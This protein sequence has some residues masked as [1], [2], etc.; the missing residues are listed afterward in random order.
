M[1]EPQAA[2][3]YPSHWAWRLYAPVAMVLGLGTLAVLCLAWTPFALVAQWVFPANRTLRVGRM[4][5]HRVFNIYTRFLTLFC[6]CRFDVKDVEALAAYPG[7]MV[8]VANHPSLLDA[9]LITSRLPNAV[10]IMKGSLVRNVLLGAG[11]RMAGYIVNDSALTVVRRGV[12]A[13]KASPTKLVI[14]PE[15]SRTRTPPV[16]TCQSTAGVIAA[17]AGV[18]VAVLTIS[19]SSPY[20]G[21]QFPLLRPPQLPLRV[22]IKQI[23]QRTIDKASAQRFGDDIAGIFAQAL[24]Q[25]NSNEGTD[26]AST[27]VDEHTPTS[28]T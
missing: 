15:G 19:M 27:A 26:T 14:F 10:C 21:K 7:S 25:A 5:I 11:S 1:P 12:D 23:D 3:N 16:D 2:P 6:G 18:P 17:R 22:Q 20:L 13:L 4:A 28:V 24:Q 9:V 8:V